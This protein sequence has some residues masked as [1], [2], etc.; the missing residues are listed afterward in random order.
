MHAMYLESMAPLI[1]AMDVLMLALLAAMLCGSNP[2]TE[3]I[4]LKVALFVIGNS[5]LSSLGVLLLMGEVL[6]SSIS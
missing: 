1:L 3:W 6:A 4:P 2:P 5:L